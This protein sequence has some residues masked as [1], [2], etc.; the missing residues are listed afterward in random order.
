LRKCQQLHREASAAFLS[1][2]GD[3]LL[4]LPAENY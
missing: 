3:T 2:G 4:G 1:F